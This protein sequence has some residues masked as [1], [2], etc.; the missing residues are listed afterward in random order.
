MIDENILDIALDLQ[1]VK[2]TIPAQSSIKLCEMIVCTR[3]L[4]FDPQ[5]CLAC[6]EELSK[7]RE[8]GDNFD[9]ELYIEESSKDMPALNFVSP[10][11]RTILSQAFKTK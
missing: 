9:F 3:Y 1:V 10:D 4:G 5:I 8:A 11:F 2:K 6:M 7:R